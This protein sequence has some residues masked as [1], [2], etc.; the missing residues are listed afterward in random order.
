MFMCGKWYLLENKTNTSV[1]R[2]DNTFNRNLAPK[3]HFWARKQHNFDTE[4]KMADIDEKIEIL[5]AA[6]H[7]KLYKFKQSQWW[8]GEVGNNGH[9]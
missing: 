9:H 8:E 2:Q 3:K 1:L 4:I 5:R 7:Q 6:M